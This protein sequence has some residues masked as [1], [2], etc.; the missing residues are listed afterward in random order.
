[1][2]WTAQKTWL[3]GETVTAAMLN[4]Y[5]RDDMEYL[6]GNAGPLQIG[7]LLEA[8]GG[9]KSTDGDVT[10]RRTSNSARG[11][12]TVYLDA[13]GTEGWF[14]GVP[15]SDSGYRFN[16]NYAGGGTALRLNSGGGNIQFFRNV[17]GAGKTL[18]FG[19]V[20][21]NGNN[22]WHAGIFNPANYQLVGSYAPSEHDTFHDDRFSLLGHT[23][24]V[25]GLPV[26]GS[27]FGNGGSSARQF[28]C[29][30]VPRLVII[31]GGGNNGNIELAMIHT[32]GGSA[33]DNNA[34]NTYWNTAAHLHGSDGFVIADGNATFNASGILYAWV[35]FP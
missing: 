17:D 32:S 5:M 2:A 10:I 28:T 8:V 18:S 4:A 19:A 23:H 22:V 35:A 20:Q 33:S 30:F 14:V 12:N 13:N 29:G 26:S 31:A 15:Q 24:S 21:V 27:Y 7:A 11:I 6:K 9:L 34:G 16:E 3:V 25:G 1:M